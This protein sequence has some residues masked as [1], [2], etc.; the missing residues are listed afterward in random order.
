MVNSFCVV[1]NLVIA[2]EMHHLA[3]LCYIYYIY[4]YYMPLMPLPVT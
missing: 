2:N 4:V 1:I 3:H